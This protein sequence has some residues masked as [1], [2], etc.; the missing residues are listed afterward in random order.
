MDSNYDDA[1]KAF[2]ASGGVIQ[3]CPP[4]RVT[5]SMKTFQASS[6]SV[7]NGKDREAFVQAGSY[8]GSIF[9]KKD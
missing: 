6:G 7:F 1:M 4:Q 2:L 9:K 3:Q 5:R 8:N